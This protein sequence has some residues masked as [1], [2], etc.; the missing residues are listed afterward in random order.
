MVKKIQLTKDQVTLVSDKDYKYLNRDNWRACYAKGIDGFYAQRNNYEGSFNGKPLRR[1]IMMHRLI[2]E[3]VIG[4]ELE[5][6]DV[7]DHINHDTL[8]NRRSNLRIVSH[9][10]NLQNM[11]RETTSKYPGVYWHKLR[12]KWRAQI[13]FNGKRKH[14]GLFND[15]REAAKAYEQA[16]RELVGEELVCKTKGRV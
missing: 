16:C 13:N 14:L 7:I 3:R 15:E 5:P 12:K 6:R 9:R 11:K 4:C 10:Q 8:D 2:M 1:T